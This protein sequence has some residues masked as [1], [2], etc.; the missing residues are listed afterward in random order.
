VTDT[1]RVSVSPASVLTSTA[2]AERCGPGSLQLQAASNDPIEWY[3]APGGNL[4]GVG[5]LFSTPALSTTTVYYAL[6]AG[7]CP[8]SPQPVTARINAV[9]T[10]PVTQDASRCGSG[11]LTLTATDTAVIRWYAD[12]VGGSVLATGN[13][14]ITPVL[15]TTTTYYAEAGSVCPG[16]RVSAQAV[17]LAVTADPVTQSAGRCGPGSV[18]LTAT[19]TAAIRWYDVASGGSALATGTTFVTPSLS[20]TTT[21]YAEA[22]IVCPSQRV[23]ATAI[24]SNGA[25]APTAQDVSRC[26]PGT[27]VLTAIPADTAGLYWYDAAA[28]GNLLAT[29][30]TYTTLSLSQSAIFY[31]QAGL[32]CPSARVP[33]HA[34]VRSN[35]ADPVVTGAQRCGGGSLTLTAVS[36][37][38]VSWYDAPA[39]IFLGNGLSFVTPSLASTTTYYAQAGSGGCLSGFVPA[40]AEIDPVSA[41]PAVTGGAVCGF[42]QVQLTAIA[43]D[44]V[45]WAASPGGVVLAT[46]AVFLTPIIAV[47]TTYYV[48]AGTA[49]PGNWIPVTATVH[50]MPEPDLGPDRLIASGDSVVLDPGSGF[51]A[52][53]WSDGSTGATLTVSTDG[54]FT[55]LVTDANGCSVSDTVT[56]NVATAASSQ[57]ARELLVIAYPNPAQDA[58]VLLHNGLQ[59]ETGIAVYDGTG[60]IVLYDV[61]RLAAEAVYRIDTRD[62]TNGLYRVRVEYRGKVWNLPVIVLHR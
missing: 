23:P 48:R 36:S 44:P 60:R 55:V 25:A 5:P 34:V 2:G 47:N 50:P 62:W 30:T 54:T 46:G 21:Y 35:A 3:D 15:T 13:S 32:D 31:V 61:P 58:L 40:T 8:G 29:G 38:P 41:D 18:T 6:A 16:N 42:G 59:G 10:D 37:D 14:F 52:Y 57:E 7:V 11:S 9:A 39:G 19:D 51:V 45:Q 53:A 4:L 12:P 49:C 43:A 24:I 27:V 1:V 20:T 26:G 56:V 17:I 28:G 22:G 33:V